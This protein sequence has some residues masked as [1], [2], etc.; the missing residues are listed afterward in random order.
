MD[1]ESKRSHPPW[2]RPHTSSV[3]WRSLSVGR[4]WT[5]PRHPHT[6]SQQLPRWT[7]FLS[8]ARSSITFPTAR[9]YATTIIAGFVTPAALTTP[10]TK[11]TIA[12]SKEIMPQLTTTTM[13]ASNEIMTQSTTIKSLSYRDRPLDSS[14]NPTNR[15]LD[16]GRNSG[17]TGKPEHPPS[18]GQHTTFANRAA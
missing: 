16:Q 4:Y 7:L 3:S 6:T 18:P 13:A 15:L 14:P 2:T 10:L 11:T 5:Y 12:T 17:R 8:V 1:T 9:L